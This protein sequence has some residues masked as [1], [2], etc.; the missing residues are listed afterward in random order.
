MLQNSA[1]DKM[2][3]VP[4]EKLEP[5]AQV[6]SGHYDGY[7]KDTDTVHVQKT[8]VDETIIV[9]NNP[10]DETTRAEMENNDGIYI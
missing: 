9:Y 5:D 10:M 4:P 2:G 3:K 1:N 7:V 6:A 8:Q